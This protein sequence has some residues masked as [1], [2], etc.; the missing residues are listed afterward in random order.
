MA[1]APITINP[2]RID[3][4]EAYLSMAEI[5]GLRSKANRLQVGALIVKDKQII[6]DGYNGMPSGAP[7]DVCEYWDDSN[8]LDWQLR[9]KREV[10]HAESNA[11]MKISEN[12]GIGAQGATLYT[13]WSPCFE[14]SKLIKQAKIKRVVYRNHYRDTA[15]LDMLK[16]YGVE[17]VHRPSGLPPTA[18]VA[19]QPPAPPVSRPEPPPSRIVPESVAP[20][21]PPIPADDMVSKLRAAA[22]ATATVAQP[23]APPTAP[24][25]V[26][27]ATAFPAESEV[28]ALL[29]AHEAAIASTQAAEARAK[30]Q[31][32]GLG[33]VPLAAPEGPYKSS[34]A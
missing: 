4:D 15:G 29:R 3:L 6:S 28:E 34:F 13:T 31:A 26:P 21:R 10:L 11:L 8:Q 5:W 20:P 18:P 25:I 7:D 33:D 27:S 23:V 1:Q 32:M 16:Q 12:G 24:T 30:A 14:C 19:P 9:T 22:A 17:L 2:N